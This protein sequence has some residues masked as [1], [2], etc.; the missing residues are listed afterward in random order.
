ML[1]V[2]APQGVRFPPQTLRVT[3]MVRMACSAR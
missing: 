2:R 3:T 1:C